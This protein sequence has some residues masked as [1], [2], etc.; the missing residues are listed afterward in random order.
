MS[1]SAGLVLLLGRVLFSIFF[2]YAAYGHWARRAMMTGYAKQMRMPLPDVAGWPT[3]LWLLVGALSVALGVWPDVGALMLG[4]FV[5]VAATFF[6]RFWEIDDQAQRQMQT[7]L[8]F[9]NVIV[10]AAVLIMFA[11]FTAAGTELRFTIIAPLFRL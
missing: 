11:T 8:F 6:H 9:R 7:Q 3:G 1:T 4:V 5:I 2:V 10:L